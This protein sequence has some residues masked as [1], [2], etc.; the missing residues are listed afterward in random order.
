L[1]NFL[2]YWF[3][4]VYLYDRICILVWRNLY[5]CMTEFVYLYDRICI[6]NGESEKQT[7]LCR[8]VELSERLSDYSYASVHSSKIF[9]FYL[10]SRILFG[11]VNSNFHLKDCQ[12]LFCAKERFIV[13]KFQKDFIWS[14]LLDSFL[15]IG[16]LE[17]WSLISAYCILY[18]VIKMF[19]YFHTKN[20]KNIKFRKDC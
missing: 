18:V 12:P 1:T 11:P 20:S 16:Q 4:F 17:T 9:S 2:E 8:T 6:L 15:Y 14:T 7:H 3:E 13:L 19:V 5:T 10:N